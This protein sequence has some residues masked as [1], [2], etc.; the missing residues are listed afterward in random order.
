MGEQT[1]LIAKPIRALMDLV[2][3]RKKEWQGIDWLI[4]GMRIN[5]EYLRTINSAD[6]RT[7]KLVYKQK[8]VKKFLDELSKELVND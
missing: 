5:Y 8:R 2:C 1:M 6:I 7:L 3:L 4:D